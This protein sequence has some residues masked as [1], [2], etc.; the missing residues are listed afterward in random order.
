MIILVDSLIFTMKWK[1]V[2]T[3]MSKRISL[4]RIEARDPRGGTLFNGKIPDLE[5]K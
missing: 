2:G 3:E 4:Y 5:P 1:A